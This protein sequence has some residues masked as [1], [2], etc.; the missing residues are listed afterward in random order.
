MFLE[1]GEYLSIAQK[2]VAKLRNVGI[3]FS[4]DNISYVA[5]FLMTADSRYKEDCGLTREEFRAYY[6]RC[7]RLLL[8]RKKRRK[9]YQQSLEWCYTEENDKHIRLKDVVED[10]RAKEPSFY[11]EIKEISD[12]IKGSPKLKEKEKNVL[13]DYIFCNNSLTSIARSHKIK[14]TYIGR[15]IDNCLRKI[16]KE[17]KNYV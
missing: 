14:P 12:L 13:N 11:V 5:E 2:V 7:A 15:Y 4:E 9:K 10:K 17:V 8:F 1:L 3:D 16:K 6:A